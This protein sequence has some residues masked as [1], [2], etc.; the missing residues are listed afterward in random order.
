MKIAVFASSAH[1][2]LGGVEELV[3]RLAQQYQLQGHEVM[4][5][6][7]RWPRDLPRLEVFEGVEILRFPF[8]RPIGTAKSAAMYLL[9][10]HSTRRRVRRLLN[11]WGADVVHVQCV[12]SNG[13]Y[14]LDASEHLQLPL[15]VTTQGE[16]TMDASKMYQ[17]DDA[18]RTLLTT[19][20]ERADA[21]TACSRKTLSDAEAYLGIKFGERGHVIFNGTNV[22]QFANA[23]PFRR[24]RPYVFALGRL[25]EQ[26]GF[27]VLI[28]AV[29]H[30]G[31]RFALDVL[32]A[33]DGPERQR[34]EQHA[35]QRGLDQRIHFVGRASRSETASYMRGAQAV[36]IPSRVD[37]GLPLVA[38]EAMAS[39]VA[40]IATES[41]GIREAVQDGVSAVLVP[42]EDSA[43]LADALCVIAS[44][45]ALRD[46][47]GTAARAAAEASF[48]WSTLGVAYLRLFRM[49]RANSVPA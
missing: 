13:L 10:T 7:N 41:G 3:H 29:N 32:I 8:R 6:T 44:D 16:V 42:M 47:L 17:R 34:L 5:L 43:R 26:K 1:P 21:F 35:N 24:E 23:E 19:L 18:A 46:R 12:S 11:A 25:V 28:D 30:A 22:A 40:L 4:V 48:D 31:E 38:I 9:T 49:I 15:V 45:S 37:E 36:V 27:D 2:H 33:G 14:A 20:A 39:G